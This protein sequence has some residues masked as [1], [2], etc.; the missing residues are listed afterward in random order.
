MGKP[1]LLVGIDEAGY[2]PV[3]GPLVVSASVFEADS[4]LLGSD[5]WQALKAVPVHRPGK[6]SAGD[7]VVGDS[8]QVYSSGRGLAGLETGVLAFASL[9][10]RPCPGSLAQFLQVFALQG[11]TP[12]ADCSWYSTGDVPLPA[13]AGEPTCLVPLRTGLKDAG[14]RFLGF[15][16]RP[17][18]EPEFNDAIEKLGNKS[19]LLFEVSAS[20]AQEAGRRFPDPR[21][22]LFLYDKQGGRNAYG[23][24]LLARFPDCGF[25]VERESHR[26]SSY[27][28]LSN[29]RRSIH[30]F[31]L[32]GDD[33]HFPIALAS[34]CSKYVRELLMKQFNAFWLSRRPNLRP[35]AGYYTDGQRFLAETADLR[36]SLGIGD[37]ALIRAR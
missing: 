11:V 37:R 27:Q 28:L 36:R 7:L 9:A 10:A 31:V 30:R 25:L 15:R 34:M 2:G 14:L 35:T 16:V 19:H 5:L 29:G 1:S 22:C 17:V 23:P 4:D 24:L 6:A 32:G 20:L 12:P 33:R 8:K 3:L 26:E 21:E 13:E 18:F